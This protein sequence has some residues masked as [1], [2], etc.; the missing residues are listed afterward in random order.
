MHKK[1]WSEN[2]K[3]TDHFGDIGI[4]GR[5]FKRILKNRVQGCGLDS[6]DSGQGP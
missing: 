2:L 5:I 4:N 3:G 1:F 6:S